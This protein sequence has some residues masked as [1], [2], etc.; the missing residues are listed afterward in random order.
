M[1]QAS[2]YAWLTATLLS[3]SS[4]EV[5]NGETNGAF[6]YDSSLLSVLPNLLRV[7]AIRLF[8]ATKTICRLRG[9]KSFRFLQ[10][11]Y[12]SHTQAV[13][14]LNTCYNEDVDVILDKV[15]VE[16]VPSTTRKT[17]L[18]SCEGIAEKLE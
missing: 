4:G 15:R 7:I 14:F 16:L 9:K 18:K 2:F 17:D 12:P 13:D 8:H 1:W 10:V 6:D 5:Y 3:R 11:T